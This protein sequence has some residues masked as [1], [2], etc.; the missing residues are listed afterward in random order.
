MGITV[1]FASFAPNL[2]G[3]ATK[4]PKAFPASPREPISPLGEVLARGT[5]NVSGSGVLEA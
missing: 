4:P 3:E 2:K 5:V 1:L